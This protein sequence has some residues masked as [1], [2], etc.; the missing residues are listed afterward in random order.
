M[1]CSIPVVSGI[2]E[3]LQTSHNGNRTGNDLS[4]NFMA[5]SLAKKKR[6]ELKVSH[7]WRKA[8]RRVPQFSCLYQ[9]KWTLQHLLIPLCC[10][11]MHAVQQ[12][13]I[14]PLSTLSL[15]VRKLLSLTLFL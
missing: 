4:Q 14:T 13:A 11:Q 12:I 3:Y 8:Q 2:D 9:R 1:P 5:S 6:F 10:R 15:L 7:K